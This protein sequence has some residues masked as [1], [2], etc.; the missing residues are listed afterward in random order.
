MGGLPWASEVQ[1]V[2]RLAYGVFPDLPVH[3]GGWEGRDRGDLPMIEEAAARRTVVRYPT[4][5]GSP[6]NDP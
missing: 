4:P 3:E 2:G 6:G 1:G 5:S